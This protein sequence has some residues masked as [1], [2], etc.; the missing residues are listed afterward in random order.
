M[1]I[2]R[3]LVLAGLIVGAAAWS[4]EGRF[5]LGA[6]AN[7]WVA[8]DDIDVD[9]VD[10]NGFSYLVSLQLRNEMAGLGLDAEMM[11]E[12]FGK[13]AYA[14]QVYFIL[15]KGVYAGAGI[16]M[17]L[18][19]GEFASEPFYSLRAGIDL[20]LLP[21]LHLDISANYRFNDTADLKD[22][23]REI[24]TDTIFLGACLRLAF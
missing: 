9:D 23:D 24:D 10:E 4:D 7:Y 3:W 11:P 20:E 22:D 17:N 21:S 5:R 12:R 1:R 13:D 6:G 19:D 18:V 14:G 2:L 15:G 8:L 16:G